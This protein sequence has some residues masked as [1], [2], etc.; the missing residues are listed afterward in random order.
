MAL[1]SYVGTIDEWTRKC[2]RRMLAIWKESTQRTVSIAQSRIRV[3]TGFARASIRA[4][5]QSMPRIDSS[6]YAPTTG[7]SVPYD[8]GDIIL[9]IA[10]AT[11]GQTIFVGWTANYVKFIND[12]TSKMAPTR[13]VDLAV[14][15]W[16]QTVS[17]VTAEAKARV[18]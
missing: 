3:D 6:A 15:Q 9:T 10:N 11:L 1:G 13:F 12:G 5:M 16:P 17:E 2:E 18:G 8:P 4:S 7:K 14:M